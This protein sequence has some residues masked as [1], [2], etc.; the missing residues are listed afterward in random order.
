MRIVMALL[1]VIL[2]QVTSLRAASPLPHAWDHGS[3]VTNPTGDARVS[4]VT[5]DAFGNTCAAG[6]YIGDVSFGGASLPANASSP[7]YNGFLVKFDYY[8]NYQ[9][10]HVFAP[11]SSAA[12]YV[13]GVAVDPAGNPY[14]TGWFNGPIDF[15]GGLI[16][17]TGVNTFL[18]KYGA[19]GGLTW[20]KRFDASEGSSVAI[21]MNGHVVLTGLLHGPC[22]FGG[23]TITPLN[24]Y[25]IF[26]AKLDAAGNHI[27]SL[28][29][30]GT[31][32]ES[33]RDIAT[34]ASSNI[35]VIGVFQGNANFGSGVL[36][37][38]GQDDIFV[39]KY[40]SSGTSLWSKK[41]GST[42][43]DDG[44]SLAFDAAGA[45][46]LT[47]GFTG[48][49]GFGGTSL[50]S[51]A[52]GDED[53]FLAKLDAAGNHLW[54]SSFGNSSTDLG[55]ALAVGSDGS[56]TMTGIFFTSVNFGGGGT[57]NS[58]GL[59]D[60]F[61]ASFSGTGSQRWNSAYGGSGNDEGNAIAVTASPDRA[62]IGGDFRS[63]INLG[64]STINSS[65][66]KTHAFVASYNEIASAVG[67][68]PTP[69][70]PGL[71]VYPNPFNPTTTVSCF[72]PAAGRVHVDVFDARGA[73]VAHLVDAMRPA[74]TFSIP[75][76]GHDLHG[77]AAGSGVY[78]VRIEQNG[79]TR[80][81]KMVLL[82]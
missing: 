29:G 58:S 15:G 50:V 51:Y 17:P 57:H 25:D 41:F 35:A 3:D 59:W 6:I 10:S 73:A 30:G 38:A 9:W 61:V 81:R 40:N 42:Q 47:G 1:L 34:D 60:V 31:S 69:P 55:T 20:V 21:D 39:A 12:C 19:V 53:I 49:V 68:G 77:R 54:S 63:S 46:F 22:D 26:I 56:V 75:W 67:S 64:G 82:K 37:S 71:S 4:S 32:Y 33:T 79:E 27:W 16:T 45:L 66:N 62:V 72:L 65:P 78:F 18:A 11:T 74:G 14:V 8:G 23:G 28:R 43:S 70:A 44:R 36:T 2:T 5:L 13:T 52:A 48:T 24:D 7:G 76:N 80:S